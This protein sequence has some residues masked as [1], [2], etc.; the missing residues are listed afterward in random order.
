MTNIMDEGINPK[1]IIIE[2]TKATSCHLN[3]ALEFEVP[4]ENLTIDCPNKISAIIDHS[5]L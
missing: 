1:M 4:D 5:V 2:I 3:L